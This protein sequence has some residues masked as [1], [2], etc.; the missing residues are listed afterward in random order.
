MSIND[1]DWQKID[2]FDEKVE[3]QKSLAREVHEIVRG[4]VGHFGEKI[5]DYEMESCLSN[6]ME[7]TQEAK[8]KDDAV[9]CLSR[10]TNDDTHIHYTIDIYL[11]PSGK[12]VFSVSLINRKYESNSV[13]PYC[14]I[15]CFR[16]GSW[17][18]HINHLGLKLGLKLEEI[19]KGEAEK[20]NQQQA[21]NLKEK[22]GR[23]D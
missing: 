5:S 22:F 10:Y 1:Y 7:R 20:S 9:D 16:V 23:L 19:Q 15:S 4:V 18:N 6:G 2:T 11:V 12:N 13:V 3:W 21:K 14:G 17:L 8:Y